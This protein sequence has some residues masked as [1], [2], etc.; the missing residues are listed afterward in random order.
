M[1]SEIVEICL[2][3]FKI[4]CKQT[5][6]CMQSKPIYL[7]RRIMETAIQETFDSNEYSCSDLGSSLKMFN[8]FKN[9]YKSAFLVTQVLAK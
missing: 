5:D 4:F 7:V 9:L 2:K 1:K 6:K 8:I 3:V